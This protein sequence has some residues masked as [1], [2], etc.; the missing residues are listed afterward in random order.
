MA[1]EHGPIAEKQRGPLRWAIWS[2][3][4]T[5][6]G[7]IDGGQLTVPGGRIAPTLLEAGCWGVLVLAL[8]MVV[9]W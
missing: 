4:T 5:R 7:S 8:S 3:I 6:E 9:L 2:R 1:A